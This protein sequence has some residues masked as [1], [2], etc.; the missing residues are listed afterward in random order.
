MK[1]AV[2]AHEEQL[3]KKI[4]VR[5]VKANQACTILNKLAENWPSVLISI[6]QS[7]DDENEPIYQI[8]EQAK[9]DLLLELA[10]TEIIYWEEI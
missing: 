9:E 10:Q 5:L 6:V 8:Y 1:L 2:I 7:A 3:V 4:L